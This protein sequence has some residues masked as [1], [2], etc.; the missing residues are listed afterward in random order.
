MDIIIRTILIAIISIII[1]KGIMMI[2]GI[3]LE[4]KGIILRVGTQ[5]NIGS[6]RYQDLNPVRMKEGIRVILKVMTRKKK[7]TIRICLDNSIS[8]IYNIFDIYIM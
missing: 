2:V 4:I 1:I 3:I 6:I 8:Y 5:G 7:V